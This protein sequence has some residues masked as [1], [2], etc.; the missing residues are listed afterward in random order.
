MQ[1]VH[2]ILTPTSHDP[3]RDFAIGTVGSLASELLTRLA[4]CMETL[5]SF[6]AT[7][8]HFVGLGCAVVTFLLLS[9]RWKHR[10]RIHLPPVEPPDVEDDVPMR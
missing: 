5:D 8:T 10:R 4:K 2:P 6:L 1:P 3:V 9:Y 7:L